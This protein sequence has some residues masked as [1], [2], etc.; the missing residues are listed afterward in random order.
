MQDVQPPVL[1]VSGA[2]RPPGQP[3]EAEAG[4]RRTAAVVA[5]EAENSRVYDLWAGIPVRASPRRPYEEAQSSHGW[6][7]PPVAAA[8]AAA[9]TL[10]GGEEGEQ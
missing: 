6:P 10:S 1:V 9:V 2:R 8:V 4:C 3:Q 7:E 5:A